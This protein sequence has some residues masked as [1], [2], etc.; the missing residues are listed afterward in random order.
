M[1]DIVKLKPVAAGMPEDYRQTLA[2]WMDSVK[3][4]ILA[5]EVAHLGLI[6]VAPDGRITMRTCADSRVQFM[7]MLEALKLDLWEDD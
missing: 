4:Q 6:L 1:S 5:G 3:E 2:G 7:G